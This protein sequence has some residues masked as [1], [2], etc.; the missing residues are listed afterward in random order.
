MAQR[1]M[2]HQKIVDTDKFMDLPQESQLLYFHLN[3]K[4]DDEGFV[5]GSKKMLKMLDM[6]KQHLNALA[7]SGFIFMF[8]SGICLIRHWH[9]HNYIRRDR[10]TDT[11]FHEEKALV[12]LDEHKVYM[13]G[14]PDSTAKEECPAN[15]DHMQAQVREGE[16]SIGKDSI[17]KDREDVSPENNYLQNLLDSDSYRFPYKLTPKALSEYAS[18][19]DIECIKYALDE[20]GRADKHSLGYVRAVLER[21]LRE[22]IVTADKLKEQMNIRRAPPCDINRGV[23]SHNYTDKDF[24]DILEK[25]EEA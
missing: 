22:G 17:D 20:A 16:D 1:R 21:L 2:I 4:A 10:R 9:L 15:D 6:K 19:M 11:I 23:L 5:S 7:D 14:S 24:K 12:H 18:K 13:M 8:D 3:L 25:M